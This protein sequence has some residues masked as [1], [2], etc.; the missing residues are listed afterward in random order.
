MKSIANIPTRTGYPTSTSFTTS[1]SLTSTELAASNVSSSVPTPT[2]GVVYTAN[3]PQTGNANDEVKMAK[4]KL[5]KVVKSVAKELKALLKQAKNLAKNFEDLLK[6][7]ENDSASLKAS[8][9]DKIEANIEDAV[10]DE[11][12]KIVNNVRELCIIL[13]DAIEEYENAL[14]NQNKREVNFNTP[15]PTCDSTATPLSTTVTTTADAATRQSGPQPT[16]TPL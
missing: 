11:A 1:T 12:E 2:T 16:V 8:D 13:Y 4:K 9:I 7:L 3:V 5:D 10:G 6:K 15:T 14:E